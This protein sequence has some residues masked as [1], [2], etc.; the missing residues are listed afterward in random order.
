MVLLTARMDAGGSE[1][2]ARK[3]NIEY[4]SAA[5]SIAVNS[6]ARLHYSCTAP[7]TRRMRNHDNFIQP[8]TVAQR[9]TNRHLNPGALAR[10]RPTKIILSPAPTIY[11]RLWLSDASIR[12]CPTLV[13]ARCGRCLPLGDRSGRWFYRLPLYSDPTSTWRTAIAA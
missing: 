2:T 9:S 11:E 8:L 3:G 4:S 13:S 6:D 10:C 12:S 1:A 5:G 7:R